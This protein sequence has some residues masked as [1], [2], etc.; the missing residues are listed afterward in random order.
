MPLLFDSPEPFVQSQVPPTLYLVGGAASLA[1]PAAHLRHVPSPAN[2][3]SEWIDH[4]RKPQRA[5]AGHLL[6]RAPRPSGDAWYCSEPGTPPGTHE[7]A[8]DSH[9]I[10]S[11]P[12][13]FSGFG[14]S[15]R[16][17]PIAGASG[18]GFTHGCTARGRSLQIVE[19]G[20]TVRCRSPET[21]ASSAV[22]QAALLPYVPAPGRR[23][24]V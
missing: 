14:E 19:P 1:S 17:T 8:G 24:P 13:R 22:L 9:I 23:S 16:A 2:G 15:A 6:L 18:T 11:R 21:V 5:P 7:R 12:P 10:S 3:E 20:T 4:P